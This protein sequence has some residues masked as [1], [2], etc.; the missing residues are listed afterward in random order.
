MRKYNP[1]YGAIY[2]ENEIIWFD[3]FEHIP[4]YKYDLM[5]ELDTGRIIREPPA[6]KLLKM[7]T[8]LINSPREPKMRRPYLY[9]LLPDTYTAR[10]A[11]LSDL[12][13]TRAAEM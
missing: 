9:S 12:P 11:V 8:K 4:P 2:E 3:D 13:F 5:W 7:I 1:K 6:G 10:P